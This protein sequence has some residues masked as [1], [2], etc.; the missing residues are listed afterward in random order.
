MGCSR[1]I[2]S[3]ILSFFLFTSVV[4]NDIVTKNVKIGGD[5]T[6]VYNKN[7]ATNPMSAVDTG[8]NPSDVIS[9][10]DASEVIQRGVQSSSDWF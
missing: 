3:V 7:A 5:N 9:G 4:A 2:G 10:K 6:A 8:K 1:L